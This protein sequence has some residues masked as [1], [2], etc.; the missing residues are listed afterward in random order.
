MKKLN[1][2]GEEYQAEKII[3]TNTDIIGRDANGNE[4]FAFR[5]ISDFTEFTLEAGQTFDNAQPT[6][7]DLQT[8]IFSLT[9]QLI[10]GGVL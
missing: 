2:S 4:V 3:K 5:G 6:I 7:I 9:S 1:F 8:Q 10:S